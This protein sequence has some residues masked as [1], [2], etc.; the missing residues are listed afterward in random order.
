MNIMNY[1]IAQIYIANY[2]WPGNNVT[3]WRNR[4]NGK[5]RWMLYDLD[6]SSNFE[7]VHLATPDFNALHHATSADGVGWPTDAAS[8]LFFAKAITKQ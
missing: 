3:V 8:T 7:I 1:H 6:W 2:D 4:N 5:W